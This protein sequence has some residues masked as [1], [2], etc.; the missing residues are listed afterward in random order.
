MSLRLWA[1]TLR[2]EA[3]KEKGKEQ[4]MFS[5]LGT[6]IIG[7]VV[8]AIAKLIVRGEEPGGCLITMA[9]GIA[10]SF[11]AFYIG[12][13]FGLTYGHPGSLRPVGFI[14]SVIGAIVLLM[15]YHL[16]RGRRR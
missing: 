6:L 13:L 1:Q 16:I 7:L 10:G 4:I 5:L 8:G 3:K 11:V 2:W 12:K 14:P 15:I 9:I